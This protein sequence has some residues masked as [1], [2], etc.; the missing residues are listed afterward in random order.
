[1]ASTQSSGVRIRQQ[2]GFEARQRPAAGVQIFQHFDP[3]IA[4]TDR[5]IF[6]K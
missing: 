4:R 5:R 1:M 6:P 2:G 3:R